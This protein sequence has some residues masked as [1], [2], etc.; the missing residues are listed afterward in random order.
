[1]DLRC[2]SPE[3]LTLRQK[4]V[5]FTYLIA[6]FVLWIEDIYGSDDIE[7]AFDE[8][9]NHQGTG[10]MPHSLH[11]DG[12]AGDLLFY[13][14]GRYVRTY[15]EAPALWDRLMAK[16][17]SLHPLCRCGGDFKSR[18]LNHFSLEHGDRQ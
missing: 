18:D 6:E 2:I 3:Q 16:W 9:T 4:R 8:L 10:H 1:M 12:L 11:Y 13:V 7:V 17:K 5:L 14:E 15:E